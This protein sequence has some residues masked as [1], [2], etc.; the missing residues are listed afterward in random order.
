MGIRFSVR[1]RLD[2]NGNGRGVYVAVRESDEPYNP[3]LLFCTH[4]HRSREEAALCR[5]FSTTSER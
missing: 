5:E 3:P 1:E 4:D 2:A